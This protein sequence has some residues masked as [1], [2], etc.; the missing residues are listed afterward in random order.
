MQP[1]WYFAIGEQNRGPA[2]VEEIRD[3]VGQGLVDSETLIWRPGWVDWAPLGETALSSLL[4]QPPPLPTSKVRLPSIAPPAPP[5][6][7]SEISD[8]APSINPIPSASKP[9][10]W[11]YIAAWIVAA[12]LSTIASVLVDLVLAST[13][14]KSRDDLDLYCLIGP[15]LQYFSSLL[16]WIWIYSLFRSL[17]ISRV[18]PF[19]WALGG[20]GVALNIG[21]TANEFERAR[22]ALPPIYLFS[23]VLGFIVFVILFRYFFKARGRLLG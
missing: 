10:A 17:N 7:Q 16:V 21:R 9:S 5:A 18:L 6:Q 14:V 22:L 19:L 15:L 2:T 8:H 1:V 20:I 3:L 13:L 23:A 12:I 11:L 4:K